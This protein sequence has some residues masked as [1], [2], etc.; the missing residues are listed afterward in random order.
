MEQ[1]AEILSDVEVAVDYAFT[2]KFVMKFYDYLRVKKAKRAEVEQ[3]LAAR[4]ALQ[5]VL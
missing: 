2:G 5:S 4:Q 3:F 1:L